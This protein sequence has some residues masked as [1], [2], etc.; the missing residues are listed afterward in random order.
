MII[1]CLLISNVKAFF[2]VKVSDIN[3]LARVFFFFF[4]FHCFIY[5]E[6]EQKILNLFCWTIVSAGKKILVINVKGCCVRQ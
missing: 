2:N 5:R 3:L 6:I 4:L 1:L